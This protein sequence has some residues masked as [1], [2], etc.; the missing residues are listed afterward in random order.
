[1]DRSISKKIDSC[2]KALLSSTNT[3]FMIVFLLFLLVFPCFVIIMM[4]ERDSY[5]SPLCTFSF[6]STVFSLFF[7]AFISILPVRISFRNKCAINGNS[8]M[9][10][11]FMQFPI[12][13]AHIMKK[14]FQKWCISS[15]ICVATTVAMCVIEMLRN[16][17]KP[18]D[19]KVGLAVLINF[20]T[21]FVIEF[22]TI[23]SVNNASKALVNVKRFAFVIAYVIY[24][25][26][27]F[28]EHK[29]WFID[30]TYNFK[31]FSGITGIIISVSI[32]PIM[33]LLT[34]IFVFDVKGKEAWHY[35]K[36]KE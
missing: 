34:K 23:I 18:I 24:F 29:K 1:M 21:L 22:L 36:I 7:Y 28:S 6:F 3:F 20:A 5:N 16:Y 14:A 27:L 32:I 9:Y 12:T 2:R 30:F 35:E 8:S 4:F 33:W 10:E 25:G 31:A 11:M 15:S 17:E 13:K 26:L 19:G